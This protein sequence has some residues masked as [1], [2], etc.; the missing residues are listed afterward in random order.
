MFKLCVVGLGSIANKAH[1][2]CLT[3]FED[4]EL[5]G[6]DLWEAPREKAIANWNIPR[7]RM[8]SDLGEM[9]R[10]VQPDG[11]YLLVPQY[12]KSYGASIADSPYES[13][14]NQILE[15]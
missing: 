1:L 2:P 3:R 11:I 10:K 12:S 13:Y 6:C 7:E 4:V 14:A 15:A 8:F 9:I 5:Y